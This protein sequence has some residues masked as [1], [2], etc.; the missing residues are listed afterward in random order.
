MKMLILPLK[1]LILPLKMLILP[2]KMLMFC[3][4]LFDVVD[5]D[6][7]GDLN[8]TETTSLLRKLGMF[9]TED[10]AHRIYKEMDVDHSGE[11]AVFAFKINDF[12]RKIMILG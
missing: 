5:L 6:G 4:R 3:D 1:R 7:S 10:E 8:Q 11:V 2:L 9:T 12:I